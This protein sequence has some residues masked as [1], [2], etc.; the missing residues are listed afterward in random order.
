MRQNSEERAMPDHARR[1]VLLSMSAAA[2]GLARPL[3][4]SAATV[5]WSAG[6]ERPTLAAPANAT[7]CHHHIYDSRFPYAPRAVLKPGEATV[8]DYRLLQQRLGTSRNVVVQPSSYGTD[9]RCLLDALARFGGQSRGVGVVTPDVSDTDLKQLHAAGVRGIRF[10]LAQGG[11]TTI[12][13]VEPLSGRAADLGWHIQVNAPAATIAAAGDLWHR[14]PCPVVFD[15]LAHVRE[16][17]GAD[18][19][20]TLVSD[21]LQRGKAWVKLSGAYMDS[22][23]GPPGYADKTAV[24]QAY[25]RMAPERLVWGSDWPHPTEKPDTKPDDAILFD[26]LAAW[27]PDQAVRD[28]ILIANPAAL[29]GFA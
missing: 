21:L 18:A 19:T 24:A 4:A 12:D 3:A 5:P 28:R 22:K 26:L 2:T 23:L 1:S 8:A 14:L 10:N 20:F 6:D 17:T 16:P 25:A 13:M 7:D 11:T 9:H 15:H 27:A 29:Y